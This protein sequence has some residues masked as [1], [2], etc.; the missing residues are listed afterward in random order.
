VLSAAAALVVLCLLLVVPGAGSAAPRVARLQGLGRLGGGS[1]RRRG[2]SAGGL[3][4]RQVALGAGLAVLGVATGVAV[5]AGPVLGVAGAMVAA[6][7]AGLVVAARRAR[8]QRRRRA[9]LVTALRA[10]VADLQAGARPA[11]ALLGAAAI[12][13]AAAFGLAAKVAAVG[14]D[15]PAALAA[16]GVAGLAGLA[17][18]W[19]LSDQTG[20]PLAEVLARLADDV[21]ADEQQRRAVA[22]A[23]AGPR[24]SALLLAGLPALGLGLGVAMGAN[25]FALLVDTPAGHVLC[26]VGVGL[27]VVG[28]A[29]TG[30]LIRRA[31]RS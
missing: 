1:S 3:T 5:V 18:A 6:T 9:G 12:S 21:S 16:S 31:Q 17:H 13:H 30:E 27:D 11:D 19:R 23:L 10:L 22:V 26:C 15:V 4:D 8:F 14:G 2:R 29:W 7:V 24:S 28:V 25:P 20:A